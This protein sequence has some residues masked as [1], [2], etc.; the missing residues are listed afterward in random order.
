MLKKRTSSW[1]L[2]LASATVLAAS[3]GVLSGCDPVPRRTLTTDEKVADLYWVYSQ[4]G[5]NYAPLEYKQKKFNFDYET[6]KNQYIEE[7]KKTTTNQEFYELLMKFVAEFKDAHTSLSLTNSSLPDRAQVA[8]LGFSGV[9]HD[10]QLLVKSLLPTNSAESNYP[11]KVGDL[12]TAVNGKAL[13]EVV[14][15]ELV[16]LRDLGNAEANYTFHFNKIFNRVSTSNGLPKA[17]EVELTVKRGD[18]TLSITLPWVI[19]DVVQFQQE[20]SAA[21][22]DKSKEVE[23]AKT[24]DSETGNFFMLSD[25][26]RSSLMKFVFIGFDGRVERLSQKY[27]AMT[28]GLKWNRLDSFRFMDAASEWIAS[29]TEKKPEEKAP[30]D[31]LA[32]LR[33]VLADAIYISG[34]NVFPSYVA[35]ISLLDAEGK[36]TGEKK[37]VGY[38]YIDTFSPSLGTNAVMKEIKNTL[39]SMNNLGVRDLIID[40]I[41]NGGGSVELGM[42]IAQALSPKKVKQPL[43]QFRLSDTWL[44]EFHGES[45]TGA[46]EATKEYFRRMFVEMK[47]EHQ[48][49]K[50]L[51]R[52]Y[53]VENLYRYAVLPND[54][55]KQPFRVKLLVNEMCASMC[56]IFAGIIQDNEMGEVIGTR[57]M[58]AGGNVVNHNQAPNSHA[59]VRQTE[60]L[61]LRLPR[62]GA[63]PD[64]TIDG[65][66]YS[67][68]ENNGITP[69]VDLAVVK[70]TQAKYAAVLDKAVEMIAKPAAATPA[71]K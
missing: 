63:T 16:K 15:S 61:L 23:E 12:I 45:R 28:K 70:H 40:T 50:R 5:E 21:K 65:V 37:L 71:S 10:D 64:V 39:A 67:Y 66:A 14:D 69:D 59:D 68:I 49:G 30:L 36:E 54:D 31:R 7:A 9:R 57:S 48:A 47:S 34:S 22:K 19:K 53:S 11:I 44:D 58:G 33:K 38:L 56:D 27:E 29:G 8:F 17:T 52:P 24:P 62:S 26:L 20:Q 32:D 4:F 60:S 35:P 46:D 6:L 42:K 2:G 43:I 18:K 51:S 3:M 25:D 13:K 55:L 41:N 1:V